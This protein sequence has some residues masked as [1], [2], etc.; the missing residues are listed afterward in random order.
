MNNKN[1]D[2]YRVLLE[3]GQ[4]EYEE[5]KSRFIATVRK[6]ESEAEA[7]GFIEEMKK[8]TGTQNIT[9][10]LSAW[11]PGENRPGAAMMGSLPGR[12][13]GLCWRFCWEK[14]SAMRRWW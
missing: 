7:V 3:G 9:A 2:S 14:A 11:G 4:G 10:M 12:R 6:C 8:S 5:K 1:V 13:D